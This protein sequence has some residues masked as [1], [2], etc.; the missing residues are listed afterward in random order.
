MERAGCLGGLSRQAGS[1]F[2]P[3][4][5]IWNS[6]WRGNKTRS[7]AWVDCQGEQEALGISRYLLATLEAPK[8]AMSQEVLE[9]Y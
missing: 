1:K 6:E 7:L 9:T 2:G 3:D 8:V 5:Q 4:T